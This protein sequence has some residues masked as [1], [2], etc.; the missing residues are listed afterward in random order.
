MTAA[1]PATI[2][3][4]AGVGELAGVRAFVREQLVSVEAD[5]ETV[6][7]LVQAVDELV[8]NVVEHGYAGRAGEIE[9]A[10]V[11]SPGEVA[12]RIRDGAPPFDPTAVPE[13]PLHLTL[14]ERKLG[15]MGVHLA[16]SLTDGF[17]HR[18]L[19]SGGNE[20]TVRK[21]WRTATEASDGHHDRSTER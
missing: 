16:R 9:V 3:V 5:R 19:P 12:F 2:R 17:D 7:D 8:C 18:I 1:T 6:D 15:G 4:R 14:S 11:R 13:P 10:F 21:R 20:V